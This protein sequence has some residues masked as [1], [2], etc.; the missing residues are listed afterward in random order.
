MSKVKVFIIGSAGTTG[1]RLKSR[2]SLR[3]DIELIEIAEQ[4]R[5]DKQEIRRLVEIADY[6]FLCLPD[7]SSREIIDYCGD[8]DTRFIDTSTAFRTDPAWAYGF[9]ELSAVHRS[10]IQ[11]SKFVAVPGCHA[12]GV[13]AVL[14]PLVASGAISSDTLLTCTSLTGYSGGGKKMIADYENPDNGNDSI[15]PKVYATSQQHKHLPEIVDQCSLD[16]APVFIP[17][18]CDYY[19]GMLVSIGIHKSQLKGNYTVEDIRKLLK[20]NYKGSTVVSVSDNNPSGLY[21]ETMSGKDSM[22]IYV[23]GNNDRILIE[24]QYDNLGKGASGA[25]VQCFNIMC[26]IDETTGLNI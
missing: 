2:L 20:D 5:K 22:T 24:S 14:S 11:T 7:A 19:S 17:I 9:P 4:L 6:A 26:G 12:G 8:C 10:K 18:V 1:L 16:N 23:S 13:I 15:S 3:D 25:A 21:A